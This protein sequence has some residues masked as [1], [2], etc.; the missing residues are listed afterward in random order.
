L[1]VFSVPDDEYLVSAYDVAVAIHGDGSADVRERI[2]FIFFDGFNNVMIPIAKNEGEEIEIDRV[3]MLR[4][5][6]I[7]ECRQLMA[8]QWDAEVFTGTYSVID[9]EDFV[10]LK[11]YGSFYR[12][13]GTV[14]VFYRVRNAITRY[15]DVAEY[16]R[17]HVPRL[18]EIRVSNINVA[19]KLPEPDRPDDVKFWLHGVIIGVR[20]FTE[21]QVI[22][23][24]VPDAVPGEYVE[25]RVIF[26]Q[27]QVPDC[28]VAEDSPAL[29]RIIEEEIEY[30]ASDKSDLIEARESAARKAGQRA[31][32]ERMKRKIRTI[33]SVLSV[34]LILGGVYYVLLVQRKLKRG[35]KSPLPHGFDGMD[36]LDPAEVRMLITGGSAGARALLG[37]LMEMASRGYISLGTR[38]SLDSRLRFTFTAADVNREELSEA[39]R[40]LVNWIRELSS[41]HEFDPIQLMG[42]M[43]SDEKAARLKGMYEGWVGKAEE[44]FHTRNI[45]DGGIAG[46]RGFGLS[47]SVL[48]LFLGLIM[49][50][51]ISAAM[52]YA[53]IP[54][55]LLML[56]YTLNIRKYTEYGT[57]QLRLWK[58]LRE[59]I[60]RG[61]A[62]FEELPGWMRS[63]TAL[64]GYGT[65][66]GIER[67]AARWIA[68][69]SGN[70]PEECPLCVIKKSAELED[71]GLDRVVK[72]TLNMMDEAISSVRDA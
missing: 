22:R 12:S 38:K 66:L 69:G 48:L 50:V 31:F 15:R 70:C 13:S 46:Y 43:D 16:R 6:E 61:P 9:E 47:Y 8:G 21:N 17:V 23:Y 59:R 72:N 62:A 60:R 7:I 44:A 26:P 58:A 20:S 34:L 53:L 57:G 1:Y 42:F 3:Y 24:D 65:A 29:E 49:P 39:E 5:D 64:L 71:C 36:R 52:G 30:L 55:G 56:T 63:C 68:S 4:K 33:F 67:G 37:K 32:Y 51:A 45:L 10:K 28:P 35:R 27:S 41:N 40:Y 54:A 18:W 2:D 19:I 11:I 25:T 14:F